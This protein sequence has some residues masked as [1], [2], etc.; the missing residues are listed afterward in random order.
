[1]AL[2]GLVASLGKCGGLLWWARW[3]PSWTAW[4]G[5]HDP[6]GEGSLR[7]D[8]YAPD[9]AGGLYQILTTILPGFGSFRYPSKL[10][11][12]TSLAVAGLAGEGWDRIVAVARAAR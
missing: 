3:V 9:G 6:L 4:L 12:L 2:V 1:M 8:G 10:L 5:P 7:S 11:T